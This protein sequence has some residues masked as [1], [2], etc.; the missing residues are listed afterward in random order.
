MGQDKHQYVKSDIW[1]WAAT[2]MLML[3]GEPPYPGMTLLQIMG[4]VSG[5]RDQR[6][7]LYVKVSC[8]TRTLCLYTTVSL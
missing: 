5:G 8:L 1:S 4:A 3:S 6:T 2:M 7:K